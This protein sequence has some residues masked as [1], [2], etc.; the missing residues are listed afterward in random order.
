MPIPRLYR[1]IFYRAYLWRLSQKSMGSGPEFDSALFI[2]AAHMMYVLGFIALFAIYFT[3]INHLFYD[4]ITGRILVIIIAILSIVIHE[5]SFL[6]NGNAKKIIDEYKD[7][8]MTKLGGVL[9]TSY[10]VFSFIFVFITAALS[11]LIN[12]I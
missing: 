1:Y 11:A 3:P 8:R 5:Y 6:S 2:A 7:S 9:V 4:K 12:Y 10:F